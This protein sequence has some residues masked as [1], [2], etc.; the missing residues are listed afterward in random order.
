M[1]ANICEN[2]FLNFDLFKVIFYV[3]FWWYI[4]TIKPRVGR[5]FLELFPS[6]EHEHFLV[7]GVA[8]GGY[9]D[10][11]YRCLEV[12]GKR[13]LWG[14]FFVTAVNQKPSKASL[15]ICLCHCGS[16]KNCFLCFQIAFFFS[17]WWLNKRASRSK[18]E[19]RERGFSFFLD[20]FIVDC[21]IVNQWQ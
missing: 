13:R 21:F 18:S 7:Y 10:S 16:L 4:I 2:L 8:L 14:S 15:C 19:V 11:H 5:N 20:D 9:E 17:D 12:G 1:F 6:I 3:L